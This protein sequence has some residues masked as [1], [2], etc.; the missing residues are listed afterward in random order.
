[1]DKKTNFSVLLA[2]YKNDKS[3]YLID[4]F[5]SVINQTVQP[6]EILIMQDGPIA[7]ELTKTIQKYKERYPQLFTHLVNEQNL[8]LGLTLARGVKACRNELIA[9]MDADDIACPKRFELQVN[10]FLKDSEL[11]LVGGY[12]EEFEKTPEKIVS[13][14]QVP[15]EET[16]IKRRI[17]TRSPFNHVTVMFKRSSVMKAGNYSD[18]RNT[19]DYNLWAKMLHIKCVM[20]NIPDTLVWVRVGNGMYERR[21]G[22]E[23]MKEEKEMQQLLLNYEMI[24][25]FQY[26]RNLLVRNTVRQLGSPARK[27]L[28]MHFLRKKIKG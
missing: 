13:V 3:E 20:R 28:Y 27:F 15:L 25:K 7:E 26:W 4:A 16:K 22:K 12:I 23:Y 19:Q 10:E 9:R 2:V 18:L 24:N 1:M 11:D 8:G 21:G 17:K 6:E 5:E 14:R